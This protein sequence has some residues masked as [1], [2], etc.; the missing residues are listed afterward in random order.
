MN[1]MSLSL[2]RKLS[3]IMLISTM[4]PLLSLGTFTYLISSSVTKEKMEQSG[5]DTL[6]QMA[7][8]LDFVINDIE[9]M[10][11]FLIGQNDIQQYLNGPEEDEQ[12][13]AR[14][15]SFMTDLAISKNYIS[16]IT[17]YPQH[18]DSTLSTTILYGT[19]LEKH[20]KIQRTY[21]KK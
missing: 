7:G 18:Y 6:G 15:L 13:K 17:I 21:E 4:L 2:Q 10:S 9:S 12:A 5:I 16:N 20:V 11:I 8:K 14:I 19:D 1:W 3:F